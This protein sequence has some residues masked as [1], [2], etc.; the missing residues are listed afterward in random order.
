MPRAHLEQP[1]EWKVVR[2]RREPRTMSAREGSRARRRSTLVVCAIYLDDT[3]MSQRCENIFAGNVQGL[4]RGHREAP[5][6]RTCSKPHGADC[7]P[8]EI[9]GFRPSFLRR[10]VASARWHCSANPSDQRETGWR[11]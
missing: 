2:W 4:T 6:G 1:L 5:P 9:T 3:Q 10:K 7:P 8:Y 11:P